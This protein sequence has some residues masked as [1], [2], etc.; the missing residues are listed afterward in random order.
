MALVRDGAA[1]RRVL[2]F[3]TGP[4]ARPVYERFGFSMR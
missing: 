3:L 1:A 4:E 2:A